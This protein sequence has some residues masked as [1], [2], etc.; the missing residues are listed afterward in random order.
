MRRVVG[1]GVVVGRGDHRVHDLPGCHRD[2]ARQLRVLRCVPGH[3]LY[4]RYEA[5][6]LLD[7]AVYGS[8][9]LEHPRGLVGPA[10][11]LHHAVG[12]QGRRRLEARLDHD[13]ELGAG[14]RAHRGV[15]LCVEPLSQRGV[16]REPGSGLGY[17]LFPVRVPQLARAV[18]LRH[19]RLARREVVHVRE[20]AAHLAQQRDVLARQPEND[21]EHRHGQPVADQGPEVRLAVG[22]QHRIEPVEVLVDGLDD[23]RCE[24]SDRLRRDERAKAAAQPGVPGR[25]GAERGVVQEL[26]A[27][28]LH[29]RRLAR[30]A[31]GGVHGAPAGSA[32]HLVARAVRGDHPGSPR[33]AYRRA[34]G[35]Q[36]VV[37]GVGIGAPFGRAQ[38][39]DQLGHAATGLAVRT[40][41]DGVC[42]LPGSTGVVR[43]WGLLLQPRHHL[44]C[45][46][47]T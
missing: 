3:E 40:G 39:P 20:H 8:R 27:R 15:G 31:P 46:R 34:H 9:V 44:V 45:R 17:E 19:P 26:Q 2:A 38:V 42:R 43:H 18:G 33:H 25:V 36:L 6:Q 5:D 21:A 14:H 4:G 35:P 10:Q 32:E 7:G 41:C 28:V 37:D 12:Q 29:P 22:A 47:T 1:V 16:L 13:V 23:L 30:G 11:E 24:V